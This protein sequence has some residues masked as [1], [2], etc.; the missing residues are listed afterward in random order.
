M[1]SLGC[2]KFR[3]LC[4]YKL[5]CITHKVIHIISP[6]YLADIINTQ[7]LSRASSKCHTMIIVKRSTL[8]A[9]SESALSVIVPKYWNALHMTLGV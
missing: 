5:L 2:L 3:Y 6:E 1:R 8:S 7:T 4:M 9:H